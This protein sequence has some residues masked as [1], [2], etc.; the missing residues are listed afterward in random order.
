LHYAD[1]FFVGGLCDFVTPAGDFY[2]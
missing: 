2:L 1:I